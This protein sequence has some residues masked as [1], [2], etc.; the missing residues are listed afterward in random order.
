MTRAPASKPDQY[1]WRLLWPPPLR[2]AILCCLALPSAA[3]VFHARLLAPYRGTVD[4]SGRYFDFVVERFRSNEVPYLLPQPDLQEI[5]GLHY[6]GSITM[7]LVAVASVV[8]FG[9]FAFIRTRSLLAASIIAK[10]NTGLV[11]KESP[12][13]PVHIVSVH[14][15][16]GVSALA[17]AFF[18]DFV[19]V[20][21]VP[22]G[23]LELALTA[24][25]W[26]FAWLFLLFGYS[27]LAAAAIMSW[28]Q[29][30]SLKSF[31]P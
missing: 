14:R 11:S 22:H 2:V 26:R 3:A 16:L 23:I 21:I 7:M 19:F 5:A 27:G 31:R 8:A 20:G 4:P 12:T 25:L 28:W 9:P 1:W 15:C 13:A 17:A 18:A 10:T 29:L 6:V 30:L 24:P